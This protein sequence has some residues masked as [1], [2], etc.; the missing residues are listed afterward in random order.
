MQH[1]V[2][3]STYYSAW[4]CQVCGEVNEVS[5]ED[6]PQPCPGPGAT[7]EPGVPYPHG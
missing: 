1:K 5:P 6:M 3:W 4:V 7:A 2:K